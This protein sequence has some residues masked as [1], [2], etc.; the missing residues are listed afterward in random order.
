MPIRQITIVGTG[1]IGGS[2]GLAMRQRGFAGTIM[3]CDKPEVLHAAILR[4]AIDRGATHAPEAVQ[5][6][7][8][9]VLATPVGTVLSLF[10]KLA[11]TLPP[12]TLITD[13]GSTKQP[14]VERAR[15]VLGAAASERVL[16][17]HPMAGKEHGG[18]ENADA[19][20]FRDAAWLITPVSDSHPYTPRQQEYIDLLQAIGARIISLDAERHDRICAWVSH[21]PQMI[22]TAL[23]SLLRE[24]LSDEEAV[25]QIG[26]RALCEM[27]RIAGSPYTMWRDIAL[28]NAENIDEALLRFEQ[29]LAHL[30]ENLRGPGLR[31]MFESANEFGRKQAG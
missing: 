3:G 26:G 14:F 30:R 25:A 12:G 2:L 5:G 16:P 29:Q 24:E 21:L 9:V 10:E 8:V 4:G 31:E 20:L 6:S 17:G 23:A 13:T 19:E 18:I 28:T 11:P 15:M 7:D 22:A 27:T 1:L